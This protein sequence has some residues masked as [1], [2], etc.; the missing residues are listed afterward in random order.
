MTKPIPN[1]DEF[2]NLLIDAID[3][4]LSSLGEA[5]K[6]AIYFHL[7]RV[8]NLSKREI[9]ARIDEFSN[10]IEDLFGLGARFLEIHIIQ[11][12]HSEVGVVWEFEA[13]NSRILPDL[14]FKQYVNFVKKYFD[15]ARQV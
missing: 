15:D 6:S 3:K 7:E 11:N 13:P 1:S 14:T 9:P 12:L 2:S 8:L 4:A 10:A 5:P